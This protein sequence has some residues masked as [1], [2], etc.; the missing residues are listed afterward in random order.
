MASGKRS[1][2]CSTAAENVWRCSEWY[3][4]RQ[5]PS[6]RSLSTPLATRAAVAKSNSSRWPSAASS[7]KRADKL[8][9][10]PN[11][12][13]ARRQTAAITAQR[14]AA[15]D[16]DRSIAAHFVVA[17][18]TP[19]DYVAIRQH[20]AAWRRLQSTLGIMPGRR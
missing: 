7:H 19:Q 17:E 13:T 20:D 12:G 18:L 8:W 9:A 16:L 1:A 11:P 6:V 3:R 15:Y 4:S 5:A 10:L 14:Q 2:R